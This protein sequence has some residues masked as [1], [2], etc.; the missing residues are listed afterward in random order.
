MHMCMHMCMHIIRG[1]TREYERLPERGGARVGL[2]RLSVVDHL[3]NKFDRITRGL[4][5]LRLDARFR[6]CA[7]HARCRGGGGRAEH[8]VPQLDQAEP[9]AL[10]VLKCAQRRLERAGVLGLDAR[11]RAH[12]LLQVA[13]GLHLSGNG[14]PAVRP[15]GGAEGLLG[16]PQLG[17]L[18]HSIVNGGDGGVDRQLPSALEEAVAHLAQLAHCESESEEGL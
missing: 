3:T 14:A 13:G 5:R 7:R 11:K 17:T 1:P 10:A 18:T 8:V 15:E 6:G 2:D 9:L 4:A 16:A 12:P